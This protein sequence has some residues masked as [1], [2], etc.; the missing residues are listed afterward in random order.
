M[1][2]NITFSYFNLLILMSEYNPHSLSK[3][4]LFSAILVIWS[5][6]WVFHIKKT[7]THIPHTF[8]H[9]WRCKYK[10]F[11]EKCKAVSLWR[12]F[13]FYLMMFWCLFTVL[14][15]KLYSMCFDLKRRSSITFKPYIWV[16]KWFIMS[17]ALSFVSLLYYRKPLL[18][19]TV[20]PHYITR[21]FTSSVH[22]ARDKD[23]EAGSIR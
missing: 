13:W 15:H 11:S 16:S 22:V 4:Y 5:S 12:M 1:S 8:Q 6:F 3:L 9:I 10:V 18:S 19:A 21:L 20:T 14:H 23:T 2:C 17:A 7:P